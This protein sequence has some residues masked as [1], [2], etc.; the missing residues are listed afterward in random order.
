M[1]EEDWNAIIIICNTI[2]DD[3][4]TSIS[5]RIPFRAVIPDIDTFDDDSIVGVLT[6][7]LRSV[8][9][10]NILKHSNED[11]WTTSGH[12][13]EILMTRSEYEDFENEC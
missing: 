6:S 2:L 8:C 7:D 13:V 1:Q 10:D 5:N 12:Q 9:S 3:M 4:Q 11:V